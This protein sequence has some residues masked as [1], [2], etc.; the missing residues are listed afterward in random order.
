MELNP[1]FMERCLQLARKGEGFAK[2]NPLVGAVVVHGGRIIGEGFHREYG[3]AHAEVNALASVKDRSLLPEST[4]YVSLEPCTHYGKTPP[5]TELIIAEKIPRVVVAVEDPNP[6]VSGKGISTMRA[7]GIEVVT[8]VLEKEA[9]EL[10]RV[11]FVNQLYRRPYVILK[12]A[13][14]RDGFMDYYRTADDGQSPVILSN[15]LT[16]TIVHKFRTQVQGI[17]VGTRT[18]L[19]D[20]PRLTARKWF[21]DHPARVVVD[22]ENRIPADASLFDGT[23]PTI[24]F[25]E[26]VPSGAAHKERVKYI[27]IDFSGDTNSQLLR[28]LYDEKI[29]SLLIEGGARLLASFIARAIWDEAYVEIADK[30]LHAGVTAPAIRGDMVASVRYPGSVQYHLKSQITRNIH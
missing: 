13:Q 18:A 7:H 20:N 4:L 29:Y 28:R 21:G 25:T 2:P 1:Q 5:C 30:S 23:A 26:S 6:K 12:W 17:M 19:L 24:V 8:G 14:S 15:A 27:E 10:N 16:H 22:R 11:F 3:K 9:R